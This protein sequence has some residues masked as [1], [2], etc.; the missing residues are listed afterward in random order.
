MIGLAAELMGAN[1]NYALRTEENKGELDVKES[2][3]KIGI[4]PSVMFAGLGRV[5]MP[6]RLRT[7]RTFAF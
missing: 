4:K 3:N 5:R 6:A 1:R 2:K 7:I